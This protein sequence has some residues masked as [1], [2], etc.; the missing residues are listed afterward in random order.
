MPTHRQRPERDPVVD[1]RRRS[2]CHWLAGL[3]L[4]GP[5]AATWAQDAAYPS[6]PIR[7]VPFGTAGGP[8]D[9]IARLYGERL[10]QRW[11]QPVVVD[12]KPGASGILAA[13][14]ATAPA[15]MPPALQAFASPVNLAGHK[16]R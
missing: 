4:G 3:A 16:L 15:A 12:A 8:I 2:T 6:R 11:G 5:G 1:D 14:F 9:I 7:I 10:T 13:D